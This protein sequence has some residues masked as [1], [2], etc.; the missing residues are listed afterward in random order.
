MPPPPWKW[1]P[2]QLYCSKSFCPWLIAYALP[3]YGLLNAVG[4]PIFG[5]GCK[6]ETRSGVGRE[7]AEMGELSSRCSLLQDSRQQTADSRRSSFRNTRHPVLIEDAI[8]AA[9]AAVDPAIDPLLQRVR[10]AADAHRDV[11]DEG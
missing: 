9:A 6:V 4:A 3:S 11:E 1:H 8:D 7:E 5:P 10:P 2:E